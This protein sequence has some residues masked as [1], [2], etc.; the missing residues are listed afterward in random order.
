MKLHLYCSAD[1]A[2]FVSALDHAVVVA[3]LYVFVRKWSR[4]PYCSCFSVTSLL[5]TNIHTRGITQT[6][7][8]WSHLIS[9]LSFVILGEKFEG[10]SPQKSN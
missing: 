9:N 10:V 7:G 6:K 2:H 5:F 3:F 1:S 4:F 8:K